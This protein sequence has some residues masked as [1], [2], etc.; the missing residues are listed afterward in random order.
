MYFLEVIDTGFLDS[1]PEPS[2]RHQQ[3]CLRHRPSSVLRTSHNQTSRDQRPQKHIR[4]F[5][6]L[7][8]DGAGEDRKARKFVTLSKTT[9]VMTY[10]GTNGVVI[11]ALFHETSVFWE[12]YTHILFHQSFLL[13]QPRDHPDDLFNFSLRP[14][15]FFD[16]MYAS[17]IFLR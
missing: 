1:K 17:N 2:W 12:E 11:W 3:R 8:K 16:V 6:R 10:W 14:F 13:P 4:G 5:K 9:M 15:F 7:S